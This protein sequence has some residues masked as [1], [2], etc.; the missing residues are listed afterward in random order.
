MSSVGFPYNPQPKVDEKLN[1][2]TNT[3]YQMPLSD[4]AYDIVSYGIEN[5]VHD[6]VFKL[7]LPMPRLFLMEDLVR[8]SDLEKLLGFIQ[9]AT[10][11]EVRDMLIDYL[12]WRDDE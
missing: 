10:L 6:I 8:N 7:E 2:I 9:P 1:R 3:V 5:R 4:L 11:S 12:Y